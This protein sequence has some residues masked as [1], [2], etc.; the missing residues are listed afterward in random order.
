M[1]SLSLD[2]HFTGLRCSPSPLSSSRFS[3]KPKQTQKVGAFA[4]S[5]VSAVAISNAQTKDRLE[6]KKMF[7]DAY[8]RCRT[9]PMEGVPFTDDDFQ[10]ALEKYDFDSELGTKVKGTVFCTD[11][12]GALV[13][14]TAKSSACLLVQ[15]ASIHK[16]K[17][18]EE[19]GIVPGL[20][21]EF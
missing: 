3:V 20:R 4:S 12:N 5:I 6:L 8:E 10:N 11:A 15:E 18:V 16:I 17:H 13:D 9:A 1:A 21:E 7:E 19:A 14:I 2:Q